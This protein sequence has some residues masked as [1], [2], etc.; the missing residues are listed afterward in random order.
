M[1]NGGTVMVN[2]KDGEPVIELKKNPVRARKISC[3][4]LAEVGV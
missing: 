4:E 3:E 1:E 2:L